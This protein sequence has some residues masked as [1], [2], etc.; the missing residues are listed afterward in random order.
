MQLNQD[1][2][3]ET[4]KEASKQL[5]QMDCKPKDGYIYSDEEG[6]IVVISSK[7]GQ[8][9]IKKIINAIQRKEN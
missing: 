7:E 6:G 4:I 3:V 9:H 1:N 5:K 8:K 2:I